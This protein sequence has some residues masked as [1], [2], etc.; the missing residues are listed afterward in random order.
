MI[1]FLEDIM[2][3]IASISIAAGIA[4]L[5]AKIIDKQMKDK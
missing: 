1:K 5:W 3:V 4:L 2:P